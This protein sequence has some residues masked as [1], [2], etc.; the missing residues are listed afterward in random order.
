MSTPGMDW[1][2]SQLETPDVSDI[3]VYSEMSTEDLLSVEGALDTQALLRLE[4]L[5]QR[6]C[7]GMDIDNIRRGAKAE[8]DRRLKEAP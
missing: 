2:E 8:L 5:S 4:C 7:E 6:T 3:P 1:F